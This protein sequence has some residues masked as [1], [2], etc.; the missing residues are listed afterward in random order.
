VV[1][2]NTAIPKRDPK[3]WRRRGRERKPMQAVLTI[4][5]IIEGIKSPV[6]IAREKRRRRIIP[7]PRIV[8][9]PPASSAC[10][11][12]VAPAVTMV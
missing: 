1:K 9:E 10:R 7:A 2:G 11:D 5:A 8:Q 3:S 6:E 4:I 12:P